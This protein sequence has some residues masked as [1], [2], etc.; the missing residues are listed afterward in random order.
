[1]KLTNKQFLDELRLRIYLGELKEEQVNIVM[2]KALED[3]KQDIRLNC[4]HKFIYRSD[5]GGY[6]YNECQLCG[7]L[8]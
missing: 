2:F 3:K 4:K 7:K 5:N 1:M 8:K 6:G